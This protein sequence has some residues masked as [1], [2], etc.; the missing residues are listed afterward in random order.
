MI[1]EYV[2]TQR[3]STFLMECL[4]VRLS[5]RRHP[6]IIMLSGVTLE[7]RQQVHCEATHTDTPCI[8]VP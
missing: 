2:R 8:S 5:V 3:S 6:T 4:L 7:E 1:N